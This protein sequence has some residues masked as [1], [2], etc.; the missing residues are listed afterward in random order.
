MKSVPKIGR[1]SSRIAV[2]LMLVLS[3][4]SLAT[5]LAYAKTKF[6]LVKRVLSPTPS[7]GGF[8]GIDLAVAGDRFLVGSRDC[9]TVCGAAH[10]FDSD[11]NPVRTIFAPTADPFSGFGE[12]VGAMGSNL[13]VGADLDDTAGPDAG[14]AYLFDGATGNL[15]Q[16]FLNPN[17]APDSSGARDNF[18]GALAGFGDDVLVG[19]ATEDIGARDAGVVYLFDGGTGQ[20][21]RT[22][23]NPT[24]ADFDLFGLSIT[25][26]GNNI[27]IAAGLDDTGVEDG[28][29]VYLFDGNGSLITT[30]V[31]PQPVFRGIF[32]S[33][34]AALGNNLLIGESRGFTGDLRAGAVHLFDGTTGAFIRTFFNPTPEDFEFYGD[35]V[36]ASGNN[37]L[38]GAIR[39]IQGP[40]RVGAAYLF[41]GT[42][43]DLT[44]TFLDPEPTVQDSF[45][46]QVAVI[47]DSVLITSPFQSSDP[48][49]ISGDGVAYLFQP[50]KIK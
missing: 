39:N 18:G 44:A 31:S 40:S 16:T 36:S 37:V 12:S 47:G 25:V 6:E 7:G 2:V 8:F 43:G 33:D 3:S 24:P 46:R 9:N 5:G 20:L 42:T 19:A 34:L 28:G 32:G 45:A 15:L 4:L 21:L 1:L 30:I 50:K 41:D 49:N 10:L 27:A 26:V 35:S 23:E 11:G 13:L 38:V 22:I 14:V 29:T 17:P 48:A